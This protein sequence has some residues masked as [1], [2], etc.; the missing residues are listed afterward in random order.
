VLRCSAKDA[1]ATKIRDVLVTGLMEDAGVD[2]CMQA[3]VQTCLYL[4]GQYWGVYN[5]REKVSR[6]FIAQH[7][8]IT[9]KDTIDVLRGN[10]VLVAGDPKCVDDYAALIDFCKSKN[11]DL[12]NYGD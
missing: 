12:S 1:V 5:L 2:L 8:S 10:G 4:N 3:Y 6:G 7:Y 11:C 9:N